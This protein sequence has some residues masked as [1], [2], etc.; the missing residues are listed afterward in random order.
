LQIYPGRYTA[1]VEGDFVVFIIGMR[2]NHG[3]LVHK[4]LPVALAMPRMLKELA[5]RPDLGMLHA[6]L[7]LSGRTLAVVQYWRSFEQLHAYAHVKDFQHLPAWS[8]F[9]RKVGGNGSVGIFH[10]TYLV[11]AGQYEC[12]F[13]NMPRSGLQHAGEMIPATG[14][15][16]SAR[17]RLEPSGQ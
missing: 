14:S 4:W 17:S 3:W 5:R 12:V 2:I 13:V 7:F 15:W 11:A 1:K 16:A 9:N 10:E 8:A 6:Q